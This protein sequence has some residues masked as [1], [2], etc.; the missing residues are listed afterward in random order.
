MINGMLGRS[1][2]GRLSTFLLCTVALILLKGSSCLDARRPYS[3]PKA[4]EVLAAVVARGHK[5]RS[6]R[7]ETRMSHRT[8]QGKIRAT[9]RLMAQQEGKLRFDAVTPFDTPLATLVSDGSRFSL[10][11]AQK[12][13]HFYGPASPCNIARL[14]GV[15]LEA[16]DILI[17]LGGSTPVIAH[18]SLR[19]AWDSRARAE[20]LT[21]TSKT[22]TQTIRLDGTNRSWDLLES[23]IRTIKGEIL[24][25]IKTG[26]VRKLQGLNLPREI[27]VWQPTAKAELDLSFKKQEINLT[28][29]TAA[30]QPPEAGGLPSKRV[31]C[32][33]VVDP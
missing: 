18:E 22:M 2:L 20:V 19:L 3:P 31:D 9:V 32:A 21:L 17:I 6:I 29:P 23:E 5:V 13:R 26:A 12:N 16:K 11:D 4:S 10:I 24:L 30:F 14:I 8:A 28:L 25:R 33:T 7:A 27:W 15:V 1:R